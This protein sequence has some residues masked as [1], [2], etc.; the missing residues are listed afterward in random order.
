[1]A[2]ITWDSVSDAQHANTNEA[3]LLTKQGKILYWPPVH[4][5]S[6]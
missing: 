5:Q 3:T 1:M 2:R 4:Q 6:K